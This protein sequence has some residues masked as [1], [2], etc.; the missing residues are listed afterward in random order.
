MVASEFNVAVEDVE[1]RNGAFTNRRTGQVYIGLQ[2]LAGESEE[3]VY[4]AHYDAPSTKPPAAHSPSYPVLGEAP[5]HFA[6]D[7]AGQVVIL[8]V[9]EETGRIRVIKLICAQDVG[10]PLIRRNVIGQIEGAAVQG[11]G[12][13][14]SEQFEV[15]NAVPKSLRLKDMGLLRF[16]DIPEIQPI[17]VE[18]PHPKGPFGAK[19]MGELAITPTA[20]AVAN[21]IHD[22]VGVW[23]NSLPITQEKILAALQ[24]SKARGKGE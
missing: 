24:A 6:Y 20:P 19:G 12:Y 2:D 11:L 17:I 16:R 3:F 10:V 4:E 22:A 9:H 18:D 8:A 23:I 1:I 15:Q 13:A 14:L 5:L 21:A 7:F